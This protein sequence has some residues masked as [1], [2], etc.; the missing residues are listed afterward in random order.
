L[1]AIRRQSHYYIKIKGVRYRGSI[2]EA[3]TKYKAQE[4]ERKIRDEIF[5]G[6]YGKAQSRKT[7][8]EFFE[9]T[10]LPW[11]KTNKRSWKSDESRIKPILAQ[12]GG[13]KLTDITSFLVEKYKITR[14]KTLTRGGTTRAK[15]TINRELALLSRLFT[16]AIRNKCASKNPV[17]EVGLFKGLTSR[18]RYLLPEEEASLIGAV[19]GHTH[20]RLV[21]LIALHTGMRRGEILKLKKK[22]VDFYRGEIHVTQ[23]KTDEDRTVPM[24]DTLRLELSS[25][26]ASHESEYLFMNPQ[27]GKPVVSIQ[28]AFEAARLE[29]GLED[30]RFHDLRHTAA[31]R[32]AEAGVD[33]FTISAILGHKDIK[34]TAR[35]AHSTAMAKRR[36]V[37]ALEGQNRESGPQIGHTSGREQRLALAK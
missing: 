32:M 22:D 6:R 10:Y 18:T 11:A 3:R 21:I 29:A 20:L 27:T 16:L 1:W 5:E 14:S 31:T 33:V 15:A 35:Y 13:K 4:A 26:I 2:P 30:F 9:E 8:K 17:A 19:A 36:A 34:T 28:R 25:H 37:A 23:T 7:L 24:N 12:F